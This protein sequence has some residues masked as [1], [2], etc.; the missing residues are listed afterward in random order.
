MVR[1]LP[2]TDWRNLPQ[3][4]DISII[5]Y[6]DAHGVQPMLGAYITDVFS[7]YAFITLVYIPHI[8]W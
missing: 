6:E 7:K 5:N 8:A 1:L 4:K 2:N 3:P